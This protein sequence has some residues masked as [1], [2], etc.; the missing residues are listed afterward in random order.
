MSNRS[1]I[2]SNL[3][4]FN[5]PTFFFKFL[6]NS[7]TLFLRSC[8]NM[9]IHSLTFRCRS[10]SINACRSWI[11]ITF[12][13]PVYSCLIIRLTFS[14]YIFVAHLSFTVL[15]F[16][17]TFCSLMHLFANNCSNRQLLR[18]S[19][20]CT[21]TFSCL[22]SRSKVTFTSSLYFIHQSYSFWIMTLTCIGRS[23]I[24]L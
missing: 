17:H 7:L 11:M 23:T 5:Y 12:V 16:S 6:I 10:S 20:Y 13:S 3:C 8:H 24:M 4:F 19:S 21:R 18:S 9:I 1:L 14:S 22:L 2:L 15:N